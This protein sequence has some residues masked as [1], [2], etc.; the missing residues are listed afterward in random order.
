MYDATLYYGERANRESGILERL[1]IRPREY[2]L[3]TVHRAENTDSEDRLRTILAGLHRVSFDI[4]V[5]FPIHPR[6]Q[7]AMVKAQVAAEW[8]MGSGS[9]NRSAILIWQ[10]W[11]KCPGHFYG[12]W[13]N[14]E[15]SLFFCVPCIAG[16]V[17][18]RDVPDFGLV[19]GVPAKQIGWVCI[20]GVRLPDQ[21]DET[22]C[23]ECDRTYAINSTSC[24]QLVRVPL[25]GRSASGCAL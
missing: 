21:D 22:S 13:R 3:A 10:C 20:C 15:G 8:P 16:A 11:K 24:Q 14:T 25:S 2:I 12:F 17:V 18:T 4:P 1:D 7:G 5:V 23:P 19:M 6:T 9:R